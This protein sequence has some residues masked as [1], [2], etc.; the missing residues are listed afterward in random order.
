M[1]AGDFQVDLL[2]IRCFMCLRKV[3]CYM[4]LVGI[5]CNTDLGMFLS[6][7][8]RFDVSLVMFKLKKIPRSG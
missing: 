2:Y 4:L 5:F 3:I 1:P 6:W 8:S 7:S